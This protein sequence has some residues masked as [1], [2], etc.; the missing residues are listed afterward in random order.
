MCSVGS[1]IEMGG[2]KTICAEAAVWQIAT[3]RRPTVASERAVAA[4]VAFTAAPKGCIDLGRSRQ[5][6]SSPA[7]AA[8]DEEYEPPGA[9]RRLPRGFGW[10]VASDREPGGTPE[11]AIPELL[12]LPDPRLAWG[13]APFRC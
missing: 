11:P 5:A 13:M 9:R 12:F 10:F 8:T 4:G 7:N 6:R 3:P 2:S 1:T